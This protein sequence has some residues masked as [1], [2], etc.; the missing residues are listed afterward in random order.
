MYHASY[1]DPIC[2]TRTTRTG[3]RTVRTA[4]QGHYCRVASPEPSSSRPARARPRGLAGLVT[5]GGDTSL[6]RLVRSPAL[7]LVA[8][9]ELSGLIRQPPRERL[10]KTVNLKRKH[11]HCHQCPPP[12]PTQP[13]PTTPSRSHPRSRHYSPCCQFARAP[14]W[15]CKNCTLHRAV[16]GTHARRTNGLSSLPSDD[17]SS[18]APHGPPGPGSQLR[19]SKTSATG[20]KGT[21]ASCA[22]A[23]ARRGQCPGWQVGQRPPLVPLARWPKRGPCAPCCRLRPL[24]LHGALPCA[25]EDEQMR[26]GNGKMKGC[27]GQ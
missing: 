8:R 1:T 26:R 11:H 20:F 17:P 9:A 2:T 18:G 7:G 5:P 16:A 19:S 12:P 15:A 27:R 21:V 13:P 14:S 4:N 22:R 3:Q 6:K 25:V 24:A 10:H 23:L